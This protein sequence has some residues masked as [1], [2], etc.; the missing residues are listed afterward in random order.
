MAN[1]EG[2]SLNDCP[3]RYQ[4][5]YEDEETGLYYNRFRYYDPN[6]GNYISQDPIRLVGNNPTLY[7]YVF[8]ANIQI[9]TLG[10][11]CSVA[12]TRKL[13]KNTKGANVRYE[14]DTFAKDLKTKMKSKNIKGEYVHIETDAPYIYSDKNGVIAKSNKYSNPYHDAIQVSDTVFDN[15]NPSGVKYDDWIN[16]LGG[17]SYYRISRDKF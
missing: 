8:D 4:G 2:R 5:Q 9:D 17:E 10:L 12:E 7:G 11:E 13:A 1:F 15:M 16:D 6:Q 3:F 14:C